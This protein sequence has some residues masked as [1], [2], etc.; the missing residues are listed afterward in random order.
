MSKRRSTRLR[1]LMGWKGNFLPRS[2][3]EKQTKAKTILLLHEKLPLFSA[4]MKTHE[5]IWLFVVVVAGATVANLITLKV[6]AIVIQ[7]KLDANPQIVSVDGA[8]ST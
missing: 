6:A 3:R 7:D 5:F 4:Y 1:S 2:I 8:P